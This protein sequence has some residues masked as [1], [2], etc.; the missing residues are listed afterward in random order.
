[1]SY[2]IAFVK[3]ADEKQSYPVQCFRAD[4]IIN[5]QVIV[6][7]SDGKLNHAIVKELRYL[8]WDCN[9][10]IECKKSEASEDE[11]GTIISPKD[12]P[13]IVGIVTYDAF[14]KNLRAIGWIPLKQK[15]KMYRGILA[16]RNLNNTAYIR[17]RKNGIDI[18]LFPSEDECS[19]IPYSLYKYGA[20]EGRVVRHAL[21]HTTFNLYEG[22][23]RFANSFA[24]DEQNLDRYFVP[25][26]SKDKRT[27]ELKE[28]YEAERR[29]REES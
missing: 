28:K 7:R 11:K 15:H 5:D 17:V 22:I 13:R 23:L 8:N 24:H 6:R 10:I 4:I 3:Y 1:M 29:V 18:Q 20:S 25:V 21:A 19:L 16:K 14:I 9:G 27:N 26:G 2:I 12:S